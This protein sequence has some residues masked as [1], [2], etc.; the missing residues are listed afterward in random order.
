MNSGILEKLSMITEEEQAILRGESVDVSLY[1]DRSGHRITGEKL[2]SKGHKIRIRPH[3]RFIDFPEHTHDY[4][5]MVYMCN[6]STTHFVNGKKIC[7]KKG[8]ILLLGR[9]ARQRIMKSSEK[10]IAVN[11]IIR[12]E[13]LSGALRYFKAEETPLRK[14]LIRALRDGE[15][16]ASLYYKVRDVLPVQNL[17]ENLLYAFINEIP[18]RREIYEMTMGLL[19]TELVNH[20][21]KISGVSENQ[22]VLF[23]VL[24]Y[25]EENFKTA[26]LSEIA[27]R[28]GYDLPELSR[29]IKKG[30]GKNFTELLIDKRMSEA[31]WLLR[32]TGKSV[33]EVGNA[34]GYENLSFFHRQFQRR[35]RMTPKKYRDCK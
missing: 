14:F 11:F 27:E 3:T 21:D 22:D 13:F 2:L 25:L 26:S 10:D 24:G 18:N 16:D 15:G 30:T 4:I 7:L 17:V 1:M 35:F 12:P 19:F 34:V 32:N 20:S 6:G 9:M 23:R 29:M 5:E 31:A 28:L 33:S 8:E